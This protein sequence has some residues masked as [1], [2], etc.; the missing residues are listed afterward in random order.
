M[1]LQEEKIHTDRDTHK[2]YIQTHTDT[3]R[4]THRLIH[5]ERERDSYRLPT[6]SHTKTEASAS[7]G[8]SRTARSHQKPRGRRQILSGFPKGIGPADTLISDFWL[9]EL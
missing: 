4:D 3:H 1:S 9:P 2:T 6:H 8:R 5:R 7:Q